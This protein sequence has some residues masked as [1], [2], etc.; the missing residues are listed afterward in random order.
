MNLI[1]Y[2]HV[3]KK[4][5]LIKKMQK[6][7]ENMPNPHSKFK[8]NENMLLD[9]EVKIN[10]YVWF[11]GKSAGGIYPLQLSLIV[12]AKLNNPACDFLQ[13]NS[14]EMLN[15]YVIDIQE[16]KRLKIYGTLKKILFN[17][18]LAFQKSFST[19]EYAVK[20]KTTHKEGLKKQFGV[21]KIYDDINWFYCE[22]IKNAGSLYNLIV[23]A[24]PN[25]KSYKILDY[26][27]FQKIGSLK[28]ERLNL[29]KNLRI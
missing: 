29:K 23:S 21:D 15:V 25:F 8:I 1:E 18:F 22:D 24:Y 13:K 17:D 26:K 2:S 16:R 14:E 11:L 9:P 19:T 20:T 3:P 28:K 7:L 4:Y 6:I 12:D 10:T 5:N 27:L